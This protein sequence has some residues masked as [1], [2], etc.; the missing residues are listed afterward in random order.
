VTPEG[1]LVMLAQSRA[2][3]GFSMLRTFNLR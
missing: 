2:T 1:V 3:L